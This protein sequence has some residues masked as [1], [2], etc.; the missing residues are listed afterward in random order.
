MLWLLVASC[1]KED[2]H[3]YQWSALVTC[4][5]ES[6]SEQSALL[7]TAVFV[8]LREKYVGRILKLKLLVKKTICSFVSK[9]S[10]RNLQWKYCSNLVRRDNQGRRLII[11]LLFEMA[12]TQTGRLYLNVLLL[13]CVLILL[14][15]IVSGVDV[16]GI[17]SG[18]GSSY[19]N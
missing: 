3:C 18:G 7:V 11:C 10:C 5:S 1:L 13:Q 17:N 19:G 2:K 8:S 16:G 4:I 15:R 9:E 6:L 12:G 14:S